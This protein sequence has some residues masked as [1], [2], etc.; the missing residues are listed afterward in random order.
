V[1]GQAD[2]DASSEEKKACEINGLYEY[3]S[4][5]EQVLAAFC[6][7][8]SVESVGMDAVDFGLAQAFQSSAAIWLTDDIAS[9]VIS[10]DAID[11]QDRSLVTISHPG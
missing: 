2:S 4:K 5:L 10:D 11:D 8:A 7:A 6:E 9:K 1:R 3:L